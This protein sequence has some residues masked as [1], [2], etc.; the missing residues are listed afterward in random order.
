LIFDLNGQEAILL[1]YQE[2]GLSFISEE[3][4]TANIKSMHFIDISHIMF[5]RF[6]QFS[7]GIIRLWTFTY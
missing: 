7:L 1:F 4:D 2:I 3:V 6:S 5:I